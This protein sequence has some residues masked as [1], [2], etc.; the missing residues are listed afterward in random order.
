MSD[1]LRCER[2]GQTVSE[3]AWTSDGLS[4][5]CEA[6]APVEDAKP[7][8]VQWWPS[9]ITQAPVYAD[10]SVVLF[11]CDCRDIL[12]VLPDKSIAHTITDPPYED[13]S[14]AYGKLRD[15]KGRVALKGLSFEKIEAG[16]GKEYASKHIVRATRG[17]IQAF[18]ETEAVGDW[19][20]A[21]EKWGA[22]WARAQWWEKPDGS[23]QMTGHKPGVPGEA[24][25]TAWGS[26][27]ERSSWNG[28]G[29]RGFYSVPVREEEPRIHDTQKPLALMLL[30][31]D[32][33]TQ[34][35]DIVLD[36]FAGSGTTGKACKQRGRRCIMVERGPFTG[37][38]LPADEIEVRNAAFLERLVNRLRG[39]KEQTL[40]FGDAG[41]LAQKATQTHI[42][43][44]GKSVRK[45]RTPRVL[46]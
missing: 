1:E 8:F 12:R 5:L 25:A 18:C 16:V 26:P 31:L 42:T 39:A 20:R 45:G 6:C 34:R 3:D 41:M 17:W 15:S 43:I 33:F 9:E 14:H 23:P 7:A 29:M 38:D 32:L 10:E 46:A 19:K 30:L 27:G 22:L 36:P 44:D 13:A 40:L 21:L 35:G 4:R 11:Y 24:I 28:G 2:C 37:A